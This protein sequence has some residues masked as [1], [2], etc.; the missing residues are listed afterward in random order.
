MCDL[1]SKNLM[2]IGA[3]RWDVKGI[4]K[5]IELVYDR[6]VH[7]NKD[8]YWIN[9]DDDFNDLLF[10]NTKLKNLNGDFVYFCKITDTFG[11]DSLS[12]LY[13]VSISDI[14]KKYQQFE[15]K[16]FFLDLLSDKLHPA[17]RYCQ[18]CDNCDGINS[19]LEELKK[20]IG[21]GDYDIYRLGELVYECPPSCEDFFNSTKDALTKDEDLFKKLFD[22]EKKDLPDFSFGNESSDFGDDF[23]VDM[24]ES[25]I[26][27]STRNSR[28]EGLRILR[29]EG[30]SFSHLNQIINYSRSRRVDLGSYFHA[31]D[32]NLN[33]HGIDHLVI[34]GIDNL[35]S[36]L[37]YKLVK[38]DDVDNIVE[39]QFSML[40][41]EKKYDII[42]KELI[43][44]V[45]DSMRRVK[46]GI[47]SIAPMYYAVDDTIS[48]LLPLFFTNNRNADC[49]LIMK[50]DVNT[51]LFEARTIINMWEAYNDV[52]LLNNPDN[53]SWLY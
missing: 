40:E 3:R 18:Q 12:R 20:K 37:R 6:L 28:L 27:H 48:Y 4:I 36:I 49:A 26:N 45:H 2:P 50:W 46:A 11:G 5:Y 23:R 21:M 29:E 17:M 44:C 32:S 35:P 33:F 53:Y 14:K 25:N 13:F 24:K 34:D 31:T 7:L 43:D 10:F 8:E 9:D 30:R 22:R 16:L 51:K 47:I 42:K 19:A 41:N 1:L 52:R 15:E 39:L 38:E